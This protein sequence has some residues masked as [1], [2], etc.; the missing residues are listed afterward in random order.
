MERTRGD[1]ELSTDPAR[2]D[3]ALIHRFLSEESYWAPGISREVVDRALDNSICFGV[4]A[5][6][7]QGTEVR[8]DADP[9]FIGKNIG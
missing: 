9:R 7:E 2:L 5:G 4:Y 6:D 8:G 3:R 1:Y